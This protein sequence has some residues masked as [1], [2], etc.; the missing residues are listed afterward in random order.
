MRVL[1][2]AFGPYD[3]W[4]DNASWRA[5][6]RLT[7]D[8][9]QLPQTLQVTTRRYP[10][11]A[12]AMRRLVAQDLEAGYEVALH[13]GQ[14][15]GSSRIRLEAIGLNVDPFASGVAAPG[16]ETAP[17]VP[18]GPVAYRSIL[19]LGAWAASLN[20]RG[21]PAQVSFHAGT[22]LCNA[23]LYYSLHLAATRNLPTRA[24]FIHLPLDVSQTVGS[25]R[26]LPAMPTEMAAEA[27]RHLLAELA[28]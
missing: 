8:L 25:A 26:E 21:I 10:V 27:L 19:P 11:E 15:P 7:A 28:S 1:L 20:A 13:L 18:D 6:V 3:E 5:L 12:A 14:A 17:L 22:Y 9:P 4:P 23:T 24:T 16:A 2:T